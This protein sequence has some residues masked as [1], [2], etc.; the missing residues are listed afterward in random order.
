M[1]F[2]A[3][4]VETPNERNDRMSAIGVAVIENGEI[5]GTF[6]SLVDPETYFAPFHMELTGITPRKVLH[7]PRFGEIW[8]TLEPL[9]AGS[10]LVAHN[11]PFDMGV[12]ARC[13]RAY[14]IDWE[15]YVPYVCTVRMTRTALP[16]L[17]DH[18]LNTLCGAWDIPLDHHRADSDSLACANL[19]LRCEER[20]IPPERFLRWYDLCEM[21]TLRPKEAKLLQNGGQ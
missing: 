3:F 9:F 15:H 10:V 6:S 17:P 18:R 21:R 13:L 4:D 5:T 16:Q 12:L 20:G 19:L 7:A 14:C 11:A 2:V 1:R 8:E